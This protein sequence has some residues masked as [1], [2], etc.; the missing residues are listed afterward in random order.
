MAGWNEPLPLM[1]DAM[2]N[3]IIATTDDYLAHV[4]WRNNCD[5]KT[6]KEAVADAK[7]PFPLARGTSKWEMAQLPW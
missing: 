7:S 6:L 4:T 2:I 3:R 1:D 5:P